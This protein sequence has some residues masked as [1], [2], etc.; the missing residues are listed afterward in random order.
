MPAYPSSEHTGT[1]SRKPVQMNRRLWFRPHSRP[2]QSPSLCTSRWMLA[3]GQGALFTTS[4]SCQS[5]EQL[6]C[7]ECLP[8]AG[9]R[10]PGWARQG[11]AGVSYCFMEED[12]LSQKGKASMEKHQGDEQ[13]CRSENRMQFLLVPHCLSKIFTLR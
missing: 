9:P 1:A 10:G 12:S 5:D 8:F 4:M 7:T 2:A 13:E 3:A 6:T 11:G